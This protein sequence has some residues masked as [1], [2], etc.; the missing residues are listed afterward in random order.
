MAGTKDGKSRMGITLQ[1]YHQVIA[2]SQTNI[3]QALKYHFTVNNP[4][5]CDFQASLGPEHDPDNT[6][7]GKILPPTI[8]LIDA[9]KA[10]QALYTIEFTPGAKYTGLVQDPNDRRHLMPKSFSAE[11]WKLVF[12]VNFSM[13]KAAQL[14]ED[15]QKIVMKTNAYSVDQLVVVFG[16]ANLLTFNW[17]KSKFPSLASDKEALLDAKTVM[18]QFIE[19]WLLSLA[20]ADPGQSHNVLGY[21][22]KVDVP[23]DASRGQLLEKIGDPKVPPSFTP[24]AVQFQTI[25]NKP[26]AASPGDPADPYNAFLFT[27]MCYTESPEEVARGKIVPPRFPSNDL[28]WSGNWFYDSIGGTMAMSSE[29]FQKEFIGKLVE[30]LH[31]AATRFAEPL[32]RRQTWDADDR[33][34][35][36]KPKRD[37][38]PAWTTPKGWEKTAE[39]HWLY[40]S[41]LQATH[42]NV[43]WFEGG[44]ADLYN[45][46]INVDSVMTTVIAAIPATG[47]FEIRQVI[48]TVTKWTHESYVFD[49]TSTF[50]W[51]Y[52]VQLDAVSSNA[53]LTAHVEYEK[54][55]QDL[56]STITDKG[57]V[58]HGVGS[59]EPDDEKTKWDR[60]QDLLKST[61]VNKM[62][63]TSSFTSKIQDGLNGQKRFVFPGGGTF[64][65]KDPIFTNAGDLMLGL[66]YRERKAKKPAAST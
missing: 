28:A 58:I 66:V 18:S 46:A 7:K 27:E 22:L 43:R 29:I 35:Q 19:K 30:P 59:D 49:A 54:G 12:F 24:A 47:K 17:D 57:K 14:P 37:F 65:M 4:K 51:K 11:G 48:Q 44:K 41:L 39:N 64:D 16:T 40:K 52:I 36:M 31:V 20:S 1:G 61:I 13:Q 2:L 53:E 9:D 10:D 63:D 15:I 50:H 34:A 3:N 42:S 56:T 45:V 21:T 6:L 55:A 25:A 38:L 33:V 60:Y 26:D 32:A 8:E 5:L 62:T 23:G